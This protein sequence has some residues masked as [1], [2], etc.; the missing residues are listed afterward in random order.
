LCESPEEISAPLCVRL[1]DYDLSKDFLY[2]VQE[3][4][5]KLRPSSPCNFEG[6]GLPDNK[7]SNQGIFQNLLLVREDR[8]SFKGRENNSKFEENLQGCAITMSCEVKKHEITV[9]ASFDTNVISK[10]QVNRFV[11][12]LDHII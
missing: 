8:N 10:K 2:A 7:S 4:W 3:E 12:Q 1:S 5:E 6:L 11:S 9:K